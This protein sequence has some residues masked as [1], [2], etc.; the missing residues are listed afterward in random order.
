MKIRS[1]L[2]VSVLGIQALVAEEPTVESLALKIEAL[3]RKVAVLSAQV[4]STNRLA[5]ASG[6]GAIVIYVR[7]DGS[8]E[9][10]GEVV[11]DVEVAKKLQ[12]VSVQFSNQPLQIRA[13]KETKF[14]DIVRVI[15]LCRK[16]GISNISFET[17]TMPDK[18]V[19]SGR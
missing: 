16:S 12:A 2:F 10:G 17:A 13:N 6:D 18:A 4:E 7:V 8:V 9:I 5:L 3:E 11:S 14:E 1:I 15:D 19:P